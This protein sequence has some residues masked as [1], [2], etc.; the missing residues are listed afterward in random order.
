MALYFAYGSC[1]S[2]KDFKRT[3]PNP[4]L[5]GPA[6]LYDY[7]LAFTKYAESRKGG[8]ADIVPAKGEKVEGILYDIEDFVELDK[9]EGHPTLYQRFLVNVVPFGETT[10]V[11]VSTYEVV[12]KDYE[13]LKPSQEYMD[14]IMDGS[15]ALSDE[16]QEALKT[17]FSQYQSM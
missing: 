12:K 17:R 2:L 10:P 13:D 8:V 7:K 1:M 16:Y 14:I 4:K 15:G 9:R 11:E 5:V 6:T 3:V